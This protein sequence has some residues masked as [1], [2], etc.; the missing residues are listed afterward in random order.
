MCKPYLPKC[1]WGPGVQYFKYFGGFS[2]SFVNLFFTKNIAYTA[3][4][5]VLATGFE[6]CTCFISEAADTRFLV[7]SL[8][9]HHIMDRLT[10]N[11]IIKGQ[12]ISK[13][14]FGVFRSTK[15]TNQIFVRISA[16]ASKRRS[17]QKSKGTLYH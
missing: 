1:E 4:W 17:N 15:K 8:N 14:L 11:V 3:E 12:L 9:A 6:A 16:L 5:M 7:S 2:G 13:C 10:D